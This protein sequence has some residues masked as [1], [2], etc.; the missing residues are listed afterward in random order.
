ME[1]IIKRKEDK[2]EKIE[3]EGGEDDKEEVRQG[4]KV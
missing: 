1:K 4:R 3:G 2:E